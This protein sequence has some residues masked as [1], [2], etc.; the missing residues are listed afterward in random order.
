ML[1]S[2]SWPSRTSARRLRRRSGRSSQRSSG[3]PEADRDPVDA[4]RDDQQVRARARRPAAP[5]RGPCRPPLRRRRAHRASS[6]ATGM[7]PP[8]AATTTAPWSDSAADGRQLDDLDGQ[9]RGDGAAPAAAGVLDDRP[10]ELARR[11]AARSASSMNAPTGLVGWANAGSSSVHHGLGH[12]RRRP[13]VS[14]P[15]RRSSLPSALRN[16]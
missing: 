1:P 16:M 2:P 10:A 4:G 15:R 12:Q 13:A 14:M 6:R 11:A 8:P 3:V 7:P 9:R 5:T